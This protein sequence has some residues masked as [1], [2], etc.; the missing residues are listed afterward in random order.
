MSC[1]SREG[2]MVDVPVIRADEDHAERAMGRETTSPITMDESSSLLGTLSSRSLIRPS[3][4]S[5]SATSSAAALSSSGTI[6]FGSMKK[7]RRSPRQA[8]RLRLDKKIKKED[9]NQRYKAAFKE[10]T[11]V[12]CAMRASGAAGS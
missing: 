6:G 7:A 9:A 8:S 1:T 2:M 10:A 12:M 11:A 4:A 5:F 3:S